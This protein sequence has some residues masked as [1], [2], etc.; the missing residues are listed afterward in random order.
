MDPEVRQEHPG[1]C[2]KCG[3]ALEQTVPIVPSARMEYT[4][5]MHPKVTERGPGSCPFCGMALEPRTVI[6]DE[7]KTRNSFR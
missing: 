5:P 6:V 4:C 3:M 2:P 1:A 7:G